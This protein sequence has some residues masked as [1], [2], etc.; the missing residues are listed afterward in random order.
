MTT[1]AENLSLFSM[2][3]T[4]VL[5]IVPLVFIIKLKLGIVKN[6]L[7]ST[8]RMTVQLLLVGVFLEYLFRLNHWAI[9]I[10]WLLIMIS[11]AMFSVLKN[12]KLQVSKVGLP[13]LSAF[14]VANMVV[15]I[16]F[17]YFIVQLDYIFDAKYMIAIGGM[18]LGNSLR[19]NIIGLGDFY[20]TLNKDEQRYL[21]QLSL[22][23]SR[24][25][26]LMPFVRQ[27]FLSALNPTLANMATMGIVSLPG[28]MTGQILGGSVPLVAI[29][30]QIAIMIAILTSTVLSILLSILMTVR[31]AF[32]QY[33]IL[34]KDIF[35]A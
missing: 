7:V 2:I 32:N 5:F 3:M 26:A 30:Y 4:G 27:S 6:I 17:N 18:I 25:E 31:R 16:Y 22:G 21:Y 28:M 19:A 12:S 11:V 1:G 29:K 35:T 15:V 13:V 9:N 10:L 24:K 20:K 34:N 23:A 33:G 8:V 14:I